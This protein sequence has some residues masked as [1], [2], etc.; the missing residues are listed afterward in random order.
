MYNPTVV[1]ARNLDHQGE[2]YFQS[3]VFHNFGFF[4]LITI[5]LLTVW[6]SGLLR[7]AVEFGRRR[8]NRRGDEFEGKLPWA[9][10]P[11]HV[12]EKRHEELRPGS[13]LPV[14]P[15]E[16]PIPIVKAFRSGE[17]LARL[18]CCNG[19]QGEDALPMN[20]FQST[21]VVHFL[22]HFRANGSCSSNF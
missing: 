17:M 13:G 1:F 15:D 18:R 8:F 16:R 14:E 3:L 20:A 21:E 11:H 10:L 5:S 12:V 4:K 7:A 9:T 22:V 6:N 2:M 19:L